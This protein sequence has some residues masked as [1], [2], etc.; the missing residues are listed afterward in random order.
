MKNLQLNIEIM[1]SNI[2]TNVNIEFNSINYKKKAKEKIKSSYIKYRFLKLN[3]LIK[4]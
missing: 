3:T 4:K 1:T 2:F